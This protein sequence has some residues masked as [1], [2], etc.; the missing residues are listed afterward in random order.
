MINLLSSP[1]QDNVPYFTRRHEN[2]Y[3]GPACSPGPAGPA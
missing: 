2:A 3:V 1:K